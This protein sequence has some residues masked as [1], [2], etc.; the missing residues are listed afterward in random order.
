MSQSNHA[1]SDTPD[2][3]FLESGDN[4]QARRPTYPTALMDTLVKY[5]THTS[6]ALDVGC[7]TG[8]LSVLLANYFDHVTATDPSQAQISNAVKYGSIDYKCEPAEQISCSN[9]SVD[10]V[11][12]AQAAHWFNLDEFYGE[13]T[14][15]IRPGGVIALI[16]Y[17]VPNIAG[18]MEALFNQFYWQD[19]HQFWPP[20]RA[21]VEQG[22]KSLAFPFHEL[23]TD[24]PDI[25]LWWNYEE[26]TGYIDTWSAASE[27]RRLN[28]ENILTNFKSE[29]LKM[30]GSHDTRYKV[31]WPVETRVGKL[32]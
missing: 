32:M 27:A 20:A 30:W 10:L 19:I 11:T 6:H 23:A 22:Y 21:H 2:N 24:I 29:L 1:S 14:R 3:Y 26:F 25:E 4:Y 16:T 9:Q 31:S 15:V 13:V 8:Q 28:S 18:P 17:G 5:C 12:V 7:G